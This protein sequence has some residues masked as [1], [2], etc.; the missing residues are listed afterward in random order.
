MYFIWLC[1]WECRKVGDFSQ[2]TPGQLYKGEPQ[3]L[4][5]TFLGGRH[6]MEVACREWRTL[7]VARGWWGPAGEPLGMFVVHQLG[8]KW[9]PLSALWLE[10]SRQVNTAQFVPIPL[11]PVSVFP[12]TILCPPFVSTLLREDTLISHERADWCVVPGIYPAL[13]AYSALHFGC[14][15]VFGN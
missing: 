5:T 7:D 2:V 13:L 3:N 6:P 12:L 10:S 9:F 11:S 4:V 8:R 14:L 1:V 15:Y